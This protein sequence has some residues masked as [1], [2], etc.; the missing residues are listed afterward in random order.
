VPP[1]PPAIDGSDPIGE[2][3]F[4]I[5]T[6]MCSSHP[7]TPIHR[8]TRQM[9]LYALPNLTPSRLL[10]DPTVRWTSGFLYGDSSRRFSSPMKR[11]SLHHLHPGRS[12]LVRFLAKQEE[13]SLLI[14]SPLGLLPRI[15]QLHSLYSVCNHF[16]KVMKSLGP[17]A[18][19]LTRTA[20]FPSQP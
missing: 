8:Y 9:V 16:L 14:F 19:T 4:V 1:V 11:S 6:C 10:A 2:S 18:L 17:W 15:S 20:I 3:H 5:S 13:L 12:S 7:P